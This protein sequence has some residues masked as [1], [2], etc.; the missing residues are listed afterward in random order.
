VQC[1]VQRSKEWAL[2]LEHELSYHQYAS[3]I[4]L[5]YD[6]EHLPESKS[7]N[8]RDV[9]LWLKKLRKEVEPEKLKYYCAG[10]YGELNGRP[11][12][13]LIIF[14]LGKKDEEL[15]NK[16]WRHGYIYVGTV[17]Y[18]SCRYVADYLQ[19]RYYGEEYIK[20]IYGDRLQPYAVMSQKI[21]K[22]YCLDNRKT[23]VQELTCTKN[24][25][26]VGIPRYY[27]K[28]LDITEDEM[29]KIAQ[30]RTK[31]LA[32]HYENKGY[33]GDLRPL[34]TQAREQAE[35]NAV[36]KLRIKNKKI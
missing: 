36:A 3:F 5:T 18:D 4:T 8:K 25:E 7:L 35:K 13:H 22:Q 27:K 30:K 20:S 32:T 1:K 28:V 12:Y 11:H 2:R 24:G 9:Q 6:D 15:M 29:S 21:G 10:E 17:T 31:E 34:I 23:I 14:G 19:K 16:H 26:P 33:K